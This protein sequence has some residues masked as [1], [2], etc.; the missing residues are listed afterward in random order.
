MGLDSTETAATS[1]L[2]TAEEKPGASTGTAWKCPK[3]G[4]TVP[5]TFDVCWQCL[6]NKAGEQPPNAQQLLSEVDGDGQEDE[7]PI[8]VGN[9]LR[10]EADVRPRGLM[11]LETTR[12]WPY[13]ANALVAAPR[14]S[15]LV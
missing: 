7:A 12:T 8:E 14:E 10:T 15:S 13:Q 9:A 5:G 4:E 11:T 2:V 3:C 6:S 1:D